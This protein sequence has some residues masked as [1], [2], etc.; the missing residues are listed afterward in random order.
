MKGV[1]LQ[2][3]LLA[4][5]MVL[6]AKKNCER[7]YSYVRKSKKKTNMEINRQKIKTV[8]IVNRRTHHIMKL[9]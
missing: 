7:I 8:V 6:A 4:D 3:L 5:D 2:K 9:D 1:T